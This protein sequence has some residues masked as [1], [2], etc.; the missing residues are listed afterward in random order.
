MANKKITFQ[1]VKTM[2]NDMLN[3][4]KFDRCQKGILILMATDN[5]KFWVA[6]DR[7]VP[8]PGDQFTN[9]FNAQVSF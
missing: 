7:N 3:K 9:L 5:K 6:R 4:W 1:A 2:A 8:I